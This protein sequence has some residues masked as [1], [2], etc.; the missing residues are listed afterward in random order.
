MEAYKKANRIVKQLYRQLN[1]WLEENAE[2]QG[3]LSKLYKEREEL[4]EKI[5]AKKAELA[6]ENRQQINQYSQLIREAEES[7]DKLLA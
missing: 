6:V 7:R 3:D 5:E 4:D 2:D 1:N